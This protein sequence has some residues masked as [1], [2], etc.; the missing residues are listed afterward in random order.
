MEREATFEPADDLPVEPLHSPCLR[1]NRERPSHLQPA[2]AL[3]Q[4]G[5]Q[6]SL[7]NPASAER[8]FAVASLPSP[9]D[10][11]QPHGPGKQRHPGLFNSYPRRKPVDK[12]KDNRYHDGEFEALYDLYNACNG[13]MHNGLL[14]IRELD[15]LSAEEAEFLDVQKLRELGEH[16]TSGCGQCQAIITALNEA[17]ETLRKKFE[18][19]GQ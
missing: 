12:G 18:A 5:E 14:D 7:S 2:F 13:A 17:R 1:T 19:E 9:G 8:S 3:T 10:P 6:H 4:A 11:P 16:V 15:D